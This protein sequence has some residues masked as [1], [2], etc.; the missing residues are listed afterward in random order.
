MLGCL[1]LIRVRVRV[2]VRGSSELGRQDRLVRVKD[3]H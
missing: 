3:C 2:R 1:I